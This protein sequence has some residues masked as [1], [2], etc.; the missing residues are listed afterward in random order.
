MQQSVLAQYNDW[1]GGRPVKV[2]AAGCG[3]TQ[4]N[5]LLWLVGK[6]GAVSPQ[7]Q[8]PADWDWVQPRDSGVP[9]LSYTGKKPIPA[10][11]AFAD[12]FRP[13]TDP[14]AVVQAKGEGAMYPL[15]REFWHPCDRVAEASSEAVARFHEDSRR[16]PPKAY[17]ANNLLP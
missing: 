3:W 7:L 1:M 9:M 2:A 15:T 13:L 5:R 16:F 6:K 11:V 14:V 8:P 4:R 17:E 10:R 12:G